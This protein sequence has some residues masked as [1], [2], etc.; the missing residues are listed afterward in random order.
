MI[1]RRVQVPSDITLRELH[2]VL[3]LAVVT[4]KHNRLGLQSS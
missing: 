4:C 1:W 2:G 3:G